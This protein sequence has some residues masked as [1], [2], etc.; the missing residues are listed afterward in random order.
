MDFATRK[1]LGS[2]AL[3]AVTDAGASYADARIG[4]YLNQFVRAQ[5]S[6]ADSI[7]NTESAGI[8][9]RVIADGTWGFAATSDVAPDSIAAT[10]R[11]DVAVAKANARLQTSPLRLASAK[12]VGDVRWRTPISNST[13]SSVTRPTTQ[14]RASRRS[15]NGVAEISSTAPIST[16]A[17]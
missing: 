7:V 11:R 9:V 16:R 3:E 2:L 8:G 1:R 14:A 10:A 17:H 12:G 4:R 6:R 13:A 5:E 15:T